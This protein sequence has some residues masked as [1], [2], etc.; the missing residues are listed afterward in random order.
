MSFILYRE[1]N[2]YEIRVDIDAAYN[3]MCFINEIFIIKL[4]VAAKIDVFAISFDFF[5]ATYTEPVKETI[6][7]KNT[8][9]IIIGI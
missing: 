7:L 3:P 4:I 9:N 6:I 8:D 1:S 5:N 2:I